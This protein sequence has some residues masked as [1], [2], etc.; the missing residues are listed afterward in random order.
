MIHKLVATAAAFLAAA[1]TTVPAPQPAAPAAPI[2]VQILAIN[3]FH[4]NI[5][6]P[7]QPVAITQVDGT[8]LKT[9]AGG[10]AQL[11][12]A[13]DRARQGQAN[14]IAIP[15]TRKTLAAIF[16]RMPSSGPPGLRRSK[17]AT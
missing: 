10:A 4:G 16:R 12:S 9:R 1:C 14:S 6:T 7:P 11:A 8:V 3:D 2:E 17:A 15:R 5:E 13:L